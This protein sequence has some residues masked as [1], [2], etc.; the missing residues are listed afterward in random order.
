[1]HFLQL[2]NCE[3]IIFSFYFELLFKETKRIEINCFRYSKI[4]KDKYRFYVIFAEK[5]TVDLQF[6]SFHT[7]INSQ[8][9]PLLFLTLY[10]F[11]QRIMRNFL[12]K[13]KISLSINKLVSLKIY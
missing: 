3:K 12:I 2:L 13:K 11:N 1:M 6:T 4:L 7:I 8:I 10:N 9:I 5:N